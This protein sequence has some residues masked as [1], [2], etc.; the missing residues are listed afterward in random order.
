[1]NKEKQIKNLV[2]KDISRIV[3]EIDKLSISPTEFL[4]TFN[5]LFLSASITFEQKKARKHILALKRGCRRK[6]NG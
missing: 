3:E 4:P 2:G 6:Y 5:R 1:M